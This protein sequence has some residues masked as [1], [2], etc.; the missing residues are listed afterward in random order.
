MKKIFVFG[1]IL[2]SLAQQA[3][4]VG[5]ENISESEFKDIIEDFTTV[6]T[7]TSV[8]PASSLGENFGFEVGAIAGVAKTDTI[9]KLS[10]ELDPSAKAENVPHAGFLGVVTFP[11][12]I[13]AELN[14]LPKIKNSDIN[15]QTGSFGIKWTITNLVP[16]P[17]DLSAKIHTATSKILWNQLVSSVATDVEYEQR[18]SGLL[19]QASKKFG[20]IEPYVSL[21]AVRSTGKLSSSS[22]SVFDTAYTAS[23]NAEEEVSG[24]Q[25]ML[26]ANLNLLIFKLGL[27][28]GRVL[29]NTKVSAK[30]SFYF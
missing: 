7:H 9:E 20:I 11:L 1:T 27:E 5:F 3:S 30:A 24:S 6:F 18:V 10:K 17:L 14:F 8:A 2:F 28:A 15:L 25:F 4:G 21:G 26:G 22:G 13:S 19:L 23:S 29:D 16:L 12:G